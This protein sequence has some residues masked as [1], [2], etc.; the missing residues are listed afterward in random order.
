MWPGGTEKAVA[1][2]SAAFVQKYSRTA[3]NFHGRLA[4]VYCDTEECFFFMN[5]LAD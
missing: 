3:A 1:V 2:F 4:T 5:A